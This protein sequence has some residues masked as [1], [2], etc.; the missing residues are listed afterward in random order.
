MSC[1]ICLSLA[2]GKSLYGIYPPFVQSTPSL[3]LSM[4]RV[5]RFSSQN[6]T[7]RQSVTYNHKIPQKLITTRIC[8]IFGQSS[9]GRENESY[10]FMVPSYYGTQSPP[11]YVLRVAEWESVLNL[12]YCALGYSSRSK[13]R[14]WNSKTWMENWTKRFQNLVRVQ[15]EYMIWNWTLKRS[16]TISMN[17]S[18]A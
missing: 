15:A 4:P 14:V 8:F 5:V 2:T 18:H 7:N 16:R 17:W 6:K 1:F 9:A 13:R 12:R 10:M 11:S 3:Q